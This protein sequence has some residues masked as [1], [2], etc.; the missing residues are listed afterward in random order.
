MDYHIEV[1]TLPVRN[2]WLVQERGF[3]RR[4]STNCRRI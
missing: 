4:A 2:T 1:I 3:T